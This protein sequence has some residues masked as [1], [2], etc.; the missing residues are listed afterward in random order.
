VDRELASLADAEAHILDGNHNTV[1]KIRGDDAVGKSKFEAI[2]AI[3]QEFER[4][5][6]QASG[7]FGSIS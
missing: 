3:L 7:M 4:T 1:C 5:T 2:L 6:T